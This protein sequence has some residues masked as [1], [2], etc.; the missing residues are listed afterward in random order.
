M[1][2][3][4]QGRAV[5]RWRPDGQLW[6][7]AGGRSAPVVVHRCFPW[8]D[9]ARHISLRDHDE[10]EFAY[11]RDVSE[12]GEKSRAA[13]ERALVAAG[14]LLEITAVVDV[15]EE[16]EIRHWAVRTRQGSRRFQTRLD[17]WPVQIAG[18]GLLIRDLAGDLYHV[19]DPEA[20]DSGSRDW[21][22]AYAG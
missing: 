13:L 5:L 6:A 9:P 18:G 14:F 1:G 10:E 4:D 21:L 17:D 20:L 16:V 8:S 7:E 12:L 15:S 22:W 2:T 11:V 19:P 3:S